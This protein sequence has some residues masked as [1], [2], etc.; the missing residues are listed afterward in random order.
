[1]TISSES[2]GGNR[3]DKKFFNRATEITVFPYV[4]PIIS[5]PT[6]G[7]NSLSEMP[8][9]HTLTSI[10]VSKEESARPNA[11]K[12]T[13]SK[14]FFFTTYPAPTGDM[15]TESKPASDHRHC[16]NADGADCKKGIQKILS[17]MPE[18]FRDQAVRKYQEGFFRFGKVPVAIISEL[19]REGKITG[20]P[21]PMACPEPAPQGS[22]FIL[23]WKEG[24]F[25]NWDLSRFG[26]A[27][28]VGLSRYMEIAKYIRCLRQAADS[29][30]NPLG[31]R[32]Q[33]ILAILPGDLKALAGDEPHELLNAF[34]AGIMFS[35]QILYSEAERGLEAVREKGDKS[36]WLEVLR[37]ALL[38]H[39]VDI[40][41]Y[42][43][44]ERMGMAVE[45]NSAFAEGARCVSWE[46][47][48]LPKGKKPLNM[49]TFR[50]MLKQAKESVQVIL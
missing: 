37:Y 32:S 50:R 36:P 25:W 40:E 27:Q 45:T 3:P 29:P 21:R 48:F 7:F 26:R 9:T 43:L 35:R 1:M 39:G 4:D 18:K 14:E 11:S 23:A 22:E 47:P 44:I 49:N 34:A 20:Y 19:A 8:D 31:T 17:S 2:A 41:P 13:V 28:N 30:E 12:F 10:P 5:I 46:W 16:R 33:E 15:N 42:T 38:R 6:L 24:Q